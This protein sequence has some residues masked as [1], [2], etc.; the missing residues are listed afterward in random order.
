MLEMK[1]I[2]VVDDDPKIVDVIKSYLQREGCDVYDAF[3][4]EQALE[5]FDRVNPDLI[6]LDLMLPRISG[7]DICRIV[8]KK[9]RVP[10]IML[11]AKV[12]ESSKISGLYMGA[13]DY[14]TKPFSPKELVARIIALFRRVAGEVEPLSNNISL[15]DGDLVIDILKREIRK[16]NE[17]VS[18]TITE[19]NV[20]MTLLKYPQK[21]F[22][23][24]E[25]MN[26]VLG[27]DNFGYERVIDTHVKNLR[28]K[29]E[30]NPKEPKYIVTVR[31]IG[32]RLGGE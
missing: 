27:E 25:L 17:L 18:L 10:I 11:T 9:S 23:R 21:A 24:E 30:S 12:D 5:I 19:F 4:G 1:K 29:I 3:D 22:T 31:G 13:D 16:K 28:Q 20:L 32:Y 15:N 26:L 7:E 8:R 6:V 14:V 2:L